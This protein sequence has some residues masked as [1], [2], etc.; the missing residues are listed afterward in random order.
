M[1]DR[2][3]W[4]RVY[5]GD[6]PVRL[7]KFLAQSGVCSRR[8]ADALIAAGEVQIDG[9]L[10]D[11]R[12]EFVAPGAKVQILQASLIA[13]GPT[14]VLNKPVG[15][16]SAQ[17]EAKQIPAARLLRRKN[18]IG[19]GDP[20]DPK[21]P[22]APLG[23]LDQD[24]RG[25]LLLSQDGVL[26]KAL[27]GPEA[28]V[29]KEYLVQVSGALTAST[30]KR[31]RFGISLDGKKLKRADVSETEPNLLRFVLTEGRKR[32]IRRMCSSVRLRVHD[33][34]RVRIGSL[35]LN[36]LPEGCWRRLSE[37]ERAELLN[38]PNT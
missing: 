7:N 32:Q 28:S 37:E 29:E 24:S 15:Y 34:E 20:P 21:V 16:V 12:G 11:P 38:P 9:R 22:L 19:A 26:A 31:L 1:P 33:L 23:R 25:L 6:A 8:E 4:V 18:Q 14:F 13:P 27:I 17:P 36:A 3:G 2:A 10:V 5:A 35:R 30:L